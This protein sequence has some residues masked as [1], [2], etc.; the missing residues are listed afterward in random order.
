MINASKYCKLSRPLNISGHSS[1]TADTASCSASY[2]AANAPWLL[3]LMFERLRHPTDKM[4]RPINVPRLVGTESYTRVALMDTD[5]GRR[6]Q[7]AI[8]AYRRLATGYD[9]ALPRR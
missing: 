6:G 1:S 9:A 3:E 8:P 4:T 5:F 2:A 7:D